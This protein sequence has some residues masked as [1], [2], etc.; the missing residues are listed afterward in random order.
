MC[1]SQQPYICTVLRSIACWGHSTL[2]PFMLL[3]KPAQQDVVLL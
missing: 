2:M 1:A 3:F